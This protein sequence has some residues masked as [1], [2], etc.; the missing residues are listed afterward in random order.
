[1]VFR[2]DSSVVTL[3]FSDSAEIGGLQ[4]THVMFPR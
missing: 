1:V 2:I 4:G 3:D